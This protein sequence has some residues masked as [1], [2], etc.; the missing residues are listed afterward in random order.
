MAPVINHIA[1]KMREEND[2]QPSMEEYQ[3][4][5]GLPANALQAR[6][7]SQKPTNKL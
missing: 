3:S 7:S 1:K 2:S 5:G 4:A 6:I